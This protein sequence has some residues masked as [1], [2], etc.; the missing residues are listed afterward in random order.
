MIRIRGADGKLI[1]LPAEARFIEVTDLQ[2][3]VGRAFILRNNGEILSINGSDALAKNYA[4]QCGVKFCKVV[5]LPDGHVAS[6]LKG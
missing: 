4:Q 3:D 5:R 6:A 1:P 2:G